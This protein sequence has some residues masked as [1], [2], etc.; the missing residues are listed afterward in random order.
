MK[1]I[2]CVLMVLCC[3]LVQAAA[4]ADVAPKTVVSG[5]FTFLLTD[6]ETAELVEYAGSAQELTVPADLYARQVQVT[7]AGSTESMVHLAN[8]TRIGNSAFSRSTSL[9]NV[10]ITEGIT[11]MGEG[12]F[13][14]CTGLKSVT[15]P[16]SLTEIGA[17]P[18][19]GCSALKEIRLPA[20][21][22]ALAVTDGALVST[23]DQRL[24]WVPTAD[25]AE[26][27]TIPAG[28]AVIG[29][30]TFYN[31]SSLKRITIPEGV[32][33]IG[34]FAFSGCSSL[35]EA[36]LPDSV[37]QVGSNPF[38]YCSNLTEIRVSADHPVLEAAEG[39]LFSRE[40]HRLVAYP[41]AKEETEYVIPQGVRIIG[42]NA[43]AT[44]KLKAVTIPD[45]VTVIE[46]GAFAMC[47]VTEAAIPDTVTCIGGYAFF[48]CDGLK[49][50][51]IP[52]SVT[53]IGEAAFLGC[54]G[55]VITLS[56]GSYAETYCKSEK[57]TYRY[58]D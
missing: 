56:P 32:T 17:Y 24:V 1:R 22:P 2:L 9:E 5:D 51:T 49:T 37:T 58:A 31:C 54:S 11:G 29:A 36:A 50:V 19:S 45:G 57:I 42:T 4:C 21:H 44:G 14:Y 35:T 15:I 12:A 26:E 6:S 38:T 16:L 3:C 30:N 33:E 10:I 8:V 23:A 34:D 27:Y 46:E 7:S 20:D 39:V 40:D 25:M 55:L 18:F 13:S 41:T 52:A 28:I 43:F 48:C 47:D 53:E